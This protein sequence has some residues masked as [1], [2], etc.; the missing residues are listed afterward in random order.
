MTIYAV[1]LDR[2]SDSAR[3]LEDLILFSPLRLD[4]NWEG[5][6]R[7]CCTEMRGKD[8]AIDN[9]LDEIERLLPALFSFVRHPNYPGGTEGLRTHLVDQLLIAV[10]AQV[11][12]LRRRW[13]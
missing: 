1:D 7:R 11:H 6:A 10:H 12:W 2:I 9:L 13:K 3:E 5:A 4:A 8:G